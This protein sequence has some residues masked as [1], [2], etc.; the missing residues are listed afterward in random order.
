MLPPLRHILEE[1]ERPEGAV[2]PLLGL[3]RAVVGE[4]IALG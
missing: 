3:G 2:G 1:G 4:G